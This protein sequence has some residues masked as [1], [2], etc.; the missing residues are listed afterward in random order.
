M[1][2]RDRGDFLAHFHDV[3]N[4][5]PG[6]LD[7]GLGEEDMARLYNE[8]G[9]IEDLVLHSH[10]PPWP[11]EADGLGPTL[12]LIDPLEDNLLAGAWAA[13]LAAHGTPG[14]INS[15]TEAVPVDGAPLRLR[16]AARRRA[17]LQLE[18]Q[19]RGRAPRRRRSLHS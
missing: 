6:Q 17:R 11:P 15:V 19:G 18:R 12:E 8:W 3:A 5:L 14:A 2:V 4:L 1:L 7:F 16:P 13:S 9:E 10:A